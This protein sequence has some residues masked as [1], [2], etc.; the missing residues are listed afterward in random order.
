[1][2][3]FVYNVL[4]MCIWVALSMELSVQNIVFGFV[5]SYTVLWFVQR[6]DKKERYFRLL[7]NILAF[8]ILFVKEVIKGSL[9]IGYDIITPSH[10]MSPGIIALPLDAKTELEI[11]SLA[12]TITL[13]PGTTSL[14]VSKDR[15]VLYVYCVY[16]NNNK[17]QVINDIKNGLEKRI[18]EV[19]R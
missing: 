7:P 4:L 8:L 10:H 18:L 11:I 16:L 17:E 1:M 6:S 9:K 14:A 12:N 3:T 2:K 15:T 19:L 13:T 5:A